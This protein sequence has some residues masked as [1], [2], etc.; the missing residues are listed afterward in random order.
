MFEHLQ[1]SD[2]SSGS[3]R[4]PGGTIV[5]IVALLSLGWAGP[6][7]AQQAGIPDSVLAHMEQTV[8]FWLTDNSAYQNEDE[9]FDHYAL[10]WKWGAGRKSLVGRLYALT[11]GEESGTFW[12]FRQFWHPGERAVI[13]QQ[14]GW[15]GTF[16]TGPVTWIEPGVSELIQI[17]YTPDGAS[18]KN[19]HVTRE[20]ATEHDGGS[21]DWVDG[22]WQARRSYVWKKQE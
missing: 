20:T 15:D 10:E 11:A 7:H 4:A 9:P 16:G 18:N 8:G 19:R 3:L 21:F 13:V 5:V 1:F 6:A 14:Y 2:R 17:F 12:D 22:Q